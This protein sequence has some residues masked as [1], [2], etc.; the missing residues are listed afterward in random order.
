MIFWDIPVVKFLI[1]HGSRR[2]VLAQLLAN[3]IRHPVLFVS[4]IN[5]TRVRNLFFVLRTQGYNGFMRNL[6]AALGQT[7]DMLKPS[8]ELDLIPIKK[9]EKL[10]DYPKLCFAKEDKPLVSVVIPVYN[11]FDYTYNCLASILKNSGDISYEVIVADDCSTDFTTKILDVAQGITVAKTA[12]NCRFLLNCNNA[13]KSARGQYILFLNNDT[14]VQPN[15]LEPLVRLMQEDSSIGMTGSKFVFPNGALQEAGGILFNDGSAWNYG[16]GMNASMP[17]Y[18]YVKEVDYIS[19]ASICIRSSL[20]KELGG[21][22]EAFAP[23]YYEDSDLAFRVRRAGYKVVYQPQSVVVH[24]EGCSN[25]TDTSCGLK[26]WQVENQK[27]FFERWKD[28]LQKE[29]FA[30]GEQIFF[31]RDRSRGKKSI[32]FLDHYVPTFDKDAGGRAAWQY[33]KALVK[34]GYNVKLLGDNFFRSEPYTTVFEQMGV[35]VLV[36][37]WYAKNWKNWLKQSPVHICIT[38][39]PHISCKY[40]DFFHSIK[41]L[42]VI[43]FLHDLTFLRRRRQYEIT[44][45]K[46]MLEL[47]KQFEK[48]E[49]HLI[50]TAD[51]SV[52]FSSVEKQVLDKMLPKSDVRVTPLFV[53]D[54]FKQK[55][56]DFAGRKDLIFV[57]GFGHD[58]NA[59]AVHW[60]VNNVF[61]SVLKAFPDIK[62]HIVGSHPPKD[63]LDLASE[64]VIVHGYVS[65]EDLLKMYDKTRICIVPLQYGAGVKGKVVEALYNQI[66]LV[67]TSVGL[68]GL[69]DIEKYDEACD[70]PEAFANAIIKMYGSKDL[71]KKNVEDNFKYVQDTCSYDAVQKI[72]HGILEG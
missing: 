8:A 55:N 14:Q 49:S 39:R 3:A 20:W 6:K 15:W 5:P 60:F 13:A 51:V 46:T 23:A 53:W 2:Q 11:Q 34:M 68:E 43:Y 32:L 70:T 66:P 7:E 56:F 52:T 4:A 24:Y 38:S 44:K 71:C 29:H 27:K 33:I 36:G 18:N 19:G 65:D 17:E 47:A 45:D 28:V 50:S 64:N 22:D 35:E 61:E 1:P 16:R 31:A 10:E 58:P 54:E 42:R 63:I 41:G 67:S 72:W 40:I 12:G 25:G 37:P 48:I 57:G 9:R 30:N 69:V 62:F 59:D 26:S 21:F